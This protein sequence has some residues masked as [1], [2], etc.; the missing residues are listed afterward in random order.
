MDMSR[1]QDFGDAFIGFSISS[2]CLLRIRKIA[3]AKLFEWEY[4]LI[5][6][7][8]T[9][10]SY[11]DVDFL[12][13]K[14]RSSSPMEKVFWK[15]PTFHRGE[16]QNTIFFR[17][18]IIYYREWLFLAGMVEQTLEKKEKITYPP[19]SLEL[20]WSWGPWRSLSIILLWGSTLCSHISFISYIFLQSTAT[21]KLP[22]DFCLSESESLTPGQDWHDVE[23]LLNCEEDL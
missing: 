3:Y 17:D 8:R 9:H 16:R 21:R 1:E 13:F 20:V 4:W 10:F 23:V 19:F 5:F 15:F 6:F 2:K 14:F 7:C 11:Y 22:H 18:L 12:R